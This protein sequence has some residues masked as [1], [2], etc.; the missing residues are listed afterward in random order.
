M[1][2]GIIK[3]GTRIGEDLYKKDANDELLKREIYEV[4]LKGGGKATVY[5]GRD[6]EDESIFYI[7]EIEINGKR[8]RDL[9]FDIEGGFAIGRDGVFLGLQNLAP[10]KGTVTKITLATYKGMENIDKDIDLDSGP[11]DKKTKY[12]SLAA[13]GPDALP[14]S[15][16]KKR[17][18]NF[19]LW[20]GV[21]KPYEPA[22]DVE[23]SE[24]F[25]YLG[26]LRVDT[27]I[28]LQRLETDQ[29]TRII[30]R[31]NRDPE[32]RA[33]KERI[34]S[35]GYYKEDGISGEGILLVNYQE[36]DGRPGNEVSTRFDVIKISDEEGGIIR[37]TIDPSFKEAYGRTYGVGEVEETA[38]NPKT[39]HVPATSGDNVIQFRIPGEYASKEVGVMQERTP[40]GYK[41]G[42]EEG[43]FKPPK[44]FTGKEEGKQQ[45]KDELEWRED[46]DKKDGTGKKEGKLFDLKEKRAER[47]TGKMQEEKKE[48]KDRKTE[49]QKEKKAPKKVEPKKKEPQK[50][51]QRISRIK[52]TAVA[53]LQKT[54]E[55]SKQLFAK[56]KQF[57]AK[58]LKLCKE[59]VQK[60][61]GQFK[62]ALEKLK[63]GIKHEIKQLVVLVKELFRFEKIKQYLKNKLENNFILNY[64]KIKLQKMIMKLEQK[65]ETI[66][67]KIRESSEKIKIQ[68]VNVLEKIKTIVKRIVEP[69]KPIISIKKY[70]AIRKRIAHLILVYLILRVFALGKRKK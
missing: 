55:V 69:I 42:K 29:R 63:N 38:S 30:L 32:E 18:E 57:L 34:V 47:K 4:N 59:K 1:I 70:E 45:K 27:R 65:L 61:I 40:D 6:R 56:I 37:C 21:V 33:K 52:E 36:F 3:T 35:I 44:E 50:F 16:K 25:N 67:I 43:T 46:S 14:E 7:H 31:K 13:H 17:Y 39:Q 26:E 68:I 5:L 9:Q 49:G 20:M 10:K 15:E 12:S 62:I 41:P 28:I 58:E 22:K 48:S 64:T 54:F 19:D 23:A 51:G 53:K 2:E 8:Y 66:K 60:I 11:I 24:Q